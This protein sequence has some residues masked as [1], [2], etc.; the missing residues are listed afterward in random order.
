MSFTVATAKKNNDE[1]NF[2]NF[3]IRRR[4]LFGILSELDKAKRDSKFPFDQQ[5]ETN[6][7]LHELN[8]TAALIFDLMVMTSGITV[9]QK[10]EPGDVQ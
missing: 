6:I 10:E 7:L 1:V 4:E 3:N 8:V 2:N 9:K 5:T